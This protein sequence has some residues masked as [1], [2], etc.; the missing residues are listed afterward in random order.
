MSKNITLFVSAKITDFSIRFRLPIAPDGLGRKAVL[1]LRRIRDFSNGTRVPGAD[2][3][4]G[5]SGLFVA[6]GDLTGLNTCGLQMDSVAL[7][8]TLLV[9]LWAEINET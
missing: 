7:R 5:Q 6:C 1:D 4:A 9:W 8:R 3:L 2:A